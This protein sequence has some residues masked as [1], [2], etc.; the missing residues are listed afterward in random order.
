MGI[1]GLDFMM[2][3]FQ[4]FDH[5]IKSPRG[6]GFNARYF[7][8][9]FMT[10]PNMDDWQKTA[11]SIRNNVTDSIIAE[12]ISALPPEVYDKHG[13][14]IEESLKSRRDQL[15]EYAKKYYWFL[16]KKVDVVGTGE[17]EFFDVMRLKDGQTTIDVYALSKKKGKNKGLLYHRQFSLDET[18]EVRLYGLDGKDKF[19]VNGEVNKGMKIRI[20]GGKGKDTIIDHSKVKGLGK[21][22]IIYDRKDKENHILKSKES[23]L[24]LSNDKAVNKYDRK[25][26]KFNRYMPL[27]SIGYNIDDG[28]FVGGGLSKKNYNFRDSTFHKITGRIAFRTGAFGISYQ[29]LYS[30][31]SRYFDLTLDANVSMP[32]NVDYFYGLGNNTEIQYNDSKYYRVRYSYAWVNP[33]LKHTVNQG[34]DYSFGA[35]YQ[36]F[37]VTDTAGRYIGELFP[38]ILDST[39]YLSHHYTGINASV[40]IDTRNDKLFPARGI[41]WKTEALGYYSI[42]EEGRNFIKLRSDLG[43][44]LSSR[45]DPRVV[46]AL[47]VGGAVNFGDYEFFHANFLGQ[48]SNLRGFRSNRFAGDQSFYQN[49]EIRFKLLNFKNYIFNGQTGF[50]LFNDIGRVWVK[51]EDSKRWHDGFGIGIWLIPFELTIFTVIYEHSKEE[52]LL[53]FHFSF[54][55]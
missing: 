9:S 31:I 40:N 35:F 15:P 39:A 52:D 18:R 11:G 54:L 49:T 7:D 50:L 12:A 47:R 36:Y 29:G 10:E 5:K 38:D 19:E 4:G 55:F 51:G 1:A 48:K 53:T 27:L 3:K 46:F 28:I 26:F 13:K 21:K 22:T 41:I 25:Q 2:P 17:R 45:R 23:K 32:R 34:I 33:Q 37:K 20:I 8:R 30:S 16:S 14:E 43:L 6:L 24:K 42:R 44:Y